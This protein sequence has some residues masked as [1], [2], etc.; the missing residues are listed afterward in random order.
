MGESRM[1]NDMLNI[2]GADVIM[3][4]LSAV[5]PVGNKDPYT[6]SRCGVVNLQIADGVARTTQGIALVTDK[7]QL[8]ASGQID[9]GAERIDLSVSPRATS[10][11]GVGLGTI[12]Q[13]VRISGPLADP[14]VGMDKANAVKTLGALGAAFATGGASLFAQ[15]AKGR[16]E[17]A[18]DP[19]QTARTWHIK[20]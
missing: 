15:G 1:R 17:G 20:K 7:M 4:V 3:Q 11:L 13:S 14:S 6:V 19:C 18:G 12:V 9:L 8:I 16:I 5:N 2:V 10:G